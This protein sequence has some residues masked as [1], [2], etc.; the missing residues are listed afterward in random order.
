MRFDAYTD[1]N[2][3]EIDVQ[4]LSQKFPKKP[5]IGNTIGEIR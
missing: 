2:V 1:Q 3:L 5:K 4:G